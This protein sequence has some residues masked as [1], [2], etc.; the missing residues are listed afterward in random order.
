MF[1]RTV[2]FNNAPQPKPAKVKTEA[3]L[4]AAA[5]RAQKMFQNN[6]MM[7]GHARSHRR[8]WWTNG[9]FEQP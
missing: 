6:G 8:A 4:K 5:T 7:H 9:R 3:Q 2:I 1:G